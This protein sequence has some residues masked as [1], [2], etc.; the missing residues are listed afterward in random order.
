MRTLNFPLYTLKE[1]PAD[2]EIA[3]HQLMLRAGLIRKLAAGL[4]NWLP[5]GIRILHKV[6]AVIREE[7]NR[8]G[9]LEVLMPAVQ[10]AELWQES[11]RW[12]HYGPELARLNDR[13]GR[14]FCLGPTHEEIITALARGEIKSYK[15]LPVNF[16]Q[17][18]TKFRDEIRP[19]FGIMRAREF[20]M[21]D[22]YSFHLDHQSLDDTY[23]TMHGTYC[24]IFSR[25]GL[26]FR[27]V[28]ADSGAIGGNLSHEFHVLAE[29]GEDAIAFSTESKYAAN[30]ELAEAVAIGSRSDPST[31]MQSLA[32]P[33]Q[34]SIEQISEFLGVTSEQCIKTLLVK[35]TD[36]S[37][38]ALL[39]RGDHELNTI[40]AEKLDLVASPLEFASNEE[41]QAAAGCSAG[42]IGPV[43]LDIPVIADRSVVNV[44][45]FVCGANQDGE[46][47]TGV[48]WERD[49]PLPDRIEDIRQVREGDPSPDG[50]GSLKIARGIEVGHIFQLGKKYS[51]AMH[52]VVLDEGGRSQAMTMGCYGIGVTRV[53]AAAIEQNHDQY[54]IIWPAAIAPFQV[55]LLPMNMHKSERLRTAV[56][57][58]YQEMLDAGIDVLF[59]NRK[60]RAGFMFADIELIGIPHRVVLGD[61]GLD[62]ATVEY[63]SRRDKDVT[64]VPLS[65]IVEFLNQRLAS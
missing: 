56:E 62:S 36:K 42:S 40:K 11:G 10:P 7:M 3:S 51:E 2:A 31:T 16:Y 19:R 18:Q 27:P 35:S 25:L 12:E 59:D 9:A 43:G 34:H 47:L 24:R 26:E 37:V 23:E 52:A 38:V 58:L 63:K 22:A 30:V 29:S 65:K 61:R 48:N 55:A 64:E 39:L 6:E 5:M 1:S 33:G 4:Y 46:H 28:L 45:D 50:E 14:E 53:I 60:V 13:H 32:T 44:A 49:L 15:Q 41:I 8:A 20:I 54:G 17:I 21:K 57:K